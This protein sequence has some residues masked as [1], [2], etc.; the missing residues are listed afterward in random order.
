[1]HTEDQ[2]LEQIKALGVQ[3]DDTLIVHTSLKSIGQLDTSAK[4]GAE[5]L[6]SA[7]RRAVPKGLLLIPAFTFA[8]IRQTPVFD[9]R[10]TQPCIG[11]VPCM[12]VQKRP[13]LRPLLPC[14]PFGGRLW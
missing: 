1:M 14:I 7:L 6:I 8:N 12:A 11:A 4:S 9:I 10:N 2:L 3:P 13:D 5:V